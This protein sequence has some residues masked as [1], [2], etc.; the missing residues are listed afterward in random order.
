VLGRDLGVRVL[1]ELSQ[2]QQSQGRGQDSD[3]QVIAVG[4]RLWKEDAGVIPPRTAQSTAAAKSGNVV[5]N[6]PFAAVQLHPCLL[7][8]ALVLG[9]AECNVA[10]FLAISA[11]KRQ[12]CVFI[13]CIVAPHTRYLLSYDILTDCCQCAHL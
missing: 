1:W 9:F 3:V 13:E 4:T 8:S 11:Q 12:M 2:E 10:L 6:S 5:S 7:S